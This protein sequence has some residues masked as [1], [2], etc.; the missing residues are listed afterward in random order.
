MSDSSLFSSC[1]PVCAWLNAYWLIS[2]IYCFTTVLIGRS[3]LPVSVGVQDY[4]FHSCEHWELLKGRSPSLAVVSPSLSGPALCINEFY[5][6]E[7]WS[8]G[9]VLSLQLSCWKSQKEKIF[10]IH[11][12]DVKDFMFGQSGP[13]VIPVQP[14]PYR[15]LPSVFFLGRGK[16]FWKKLRDTDTLP[17]L[18]LNP[19][20]T[21]RKRKKSNFPFSLLYRAQIVHSQNKGTLR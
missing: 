1:F 9:R 15:L 17:F 5:R 12:F 7:Q 18:L 11:S 20:A 6:V 13:A 10:F 19:V 8:S 16:K 14:L 3:G 21:I 2:L 4:W